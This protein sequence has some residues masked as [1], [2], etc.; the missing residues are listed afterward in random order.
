MSENP[1]IQYIR[2][3]VIPCFARLFSRRRLLSSLCLCFTLLICAVLLSALCLTFGQNL[4]SLDSFSAE[5]DTYITTHGV[6]AG[7]RAFRESVRTVL[8]YA[9]AE[10]YVTHVC[11]V[12]LWLVT[13]LAAVYRVFTE[14]VATEK[15]VYALYIIYGADTKLLRKGIIREFWIL[16]LPA[17][18]LSLP[19]GLWLTRD[20][21]AVS[22]F[23]FLWVAEMLI[24]FFLL[25]LLCARQVT[26]KLFKE[27]C[28][29][30]MTAID[31]SEYIQSPRRIS[32]KKTLRRRSGFGYALLSFGRMKSMESGY[33]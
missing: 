4:T 33:S 9:Q 23:S 26:R 1:I 28:V 5:F 25:S 10:V 18:L 14:S 8:T 24:S 19:L 27:S 3:T 12:G 17:I 32:L 21:N 15:Y 20:S 31:T 13:A 7:N 22:G 11:F 16:G 2:L 30:L 29:S 6:N